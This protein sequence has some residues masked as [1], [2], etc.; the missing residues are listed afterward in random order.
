MTYKYNLNR[1][2]IFLSLALLL[3]ACTKNFDSINTN[4]SLV[5]K[6][7]MKPNLLLTYV[8]KNSIFESYSGGIITEWAGYYSNPATNTL[9]NRN[10]ADPFQ[11]YYNSYIL[12]IS[13][14]IRLTQDNP[15]Q[16]NQ[17]AIARIWKVWLFHQ[18]TDAY[19]DIPYFE[20]A[21]DVAEANTAPVYDS[22]EL[23]YK[24]MLN[25][26]KVAAAALTVDPGQLSYGTSDLLY[27]GDINSWIRFANSLRLRLAMRVRYK[28][29]QLAQQ[30][31][32]EVIN[33][34]LIET[35]NQNAAL[36]TEGEGAVDINNRN[37]IFNRNVSNTIPVYASLTTTETLKAKNDPRLTIY[38]LP[39]VAPDDGD[40]YRGRPLAVDTDLEPGW[41][42]G[43]RY[44]QENTAYLG[45]LFTRAAYNIIV[46]NAAEVSF[47]RAEAALAGFSSED[48]DALFTQGIRLAMERYNVSSDDINDYL[49]SPAGLLTGSEED[50]LQEII[51]QK[52]LGNY[53]QSNESWAEYRRTGYPLIWVGS[54][55]GDT[56][57]KVPRRLT[58]TQDEYFK[59]EANLM[60]AVNKLSDGDFYQSKLWW[61]AKAGLPFAHP[62][63]GMF[64]PEQ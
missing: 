35:N 33:A 2:G 51:V 61:D 19:G 28:D 57:K 34:P 53:Y 14:A 32:S 24:D 46:M 11:R 64:P 37:P 52:W 22:Q 18:L 58:Y 43:P 59:N 1:I 49:A 45:E 15:Y 6:E 39:A 20:A 42:L 8:Q 54:Q 48:K 10:W 21:L 5:T 16:A 63:Q 44:R 50:Q 13:E 12:N 56:D 9:A 38:V 26:L 29:A 30:H 62:K 47:L 3:N 55:I 25:E 41:T 31:I 7:V 36:L 17:H 60:Q 4:P 40:P 27:K 23:I